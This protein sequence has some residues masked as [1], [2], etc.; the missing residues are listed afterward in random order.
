MLV[1]RW[2]PS[3][4]GAFIHKQQFFLLQASLSLL[5]LSSLHLFFSQTTGCIWC[6]F[7]KH[8]K[9]DDSVPQEAT[10]QPATLLS[11]SEWVTE[12]IFCQRW[13][14]PKSI[15]WLSFAHLIS[16]CLHIHAVIAMASLSPLPP[17]RP[18]SLPFFLVDSVR[19]LCGKVQRVGWAWNRRLPATIHY[20]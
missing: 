17:V 19:C 13:S 6:I 16:S 15:N 11:S 20:R 8:H 12:W 5:H 7:R 3:R 9:G 4:S 1:H 14:L 10:L 18:L 2:R